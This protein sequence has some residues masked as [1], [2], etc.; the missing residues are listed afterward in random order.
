[1]CLNLRAL[2]PLATTG[3]DV[4]VEDL[5][6]LSSDCDHSSTLSH[7]SRAESRVAIKDAVEM[8]RDVAQQ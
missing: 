7:A 4:R 2:L 8:G 6:S 3:D 1:M 5:V